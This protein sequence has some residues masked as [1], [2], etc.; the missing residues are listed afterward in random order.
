M[1]KKYCAVDGFKREEGVTNAEMGVE[2]MSGPLSPK[3]PVF[4]SG[5]K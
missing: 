1:Q 2:E 4:D 5:V 3:P